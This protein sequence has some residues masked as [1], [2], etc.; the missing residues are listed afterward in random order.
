MAGRQRPAEARFEPLVASLFRRA[1]WKVKV[2][3]RVGSRRA[4]LLVRRGERA[5]VVELKIAPEG[6]RDRLVPLL[7]QAILEARS[8]AREVP[9]GAAPLAVVAA[10]RIPDPV[11]AELKEFCLSHAPDAAIGVIDLEGLR[12]FVGPALDSLNAPRASGRRLHSQAHEPVIHLFS[13][14]NQWMLKVLLAPQ[15]PEPLLA[16]P[17]GEYKNASQLASAAQV[18][19]M[20]AFRFLRQLGQEGF[21][22]ESAGA[23]HL[24]RLEELF[25]RWQAASLRPVRELPARWIIRGD[26]KRQLGEALRSPPSRAC[27]GL[28]AAADAL[29]FG[30]VHGVPPHIYVEDLRPA[31]LRQLG[32]SAEVSGQPDVFLRVPSAPEAVFRGA[33]R[34]SEVPACDVI[35]VWLDVSA[36]PARGHEQAALVHR[37]ILQPLLKPRR[38]T[39]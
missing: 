29:G 24:V 17:R 11:V 18:S 36:H 5:Y 32:L 4:D 33:V 14:L 35:Q 25:N 3:P 13:D 34:K 22:D 10:P 37:R 20:S 21:L 8:V 9:E 2:E 15:I 39:T 6:R 1:G 23:L 38:T 27:L 31:G 30:F 16:A 26:P 12:A 28:F 19:I 7:A